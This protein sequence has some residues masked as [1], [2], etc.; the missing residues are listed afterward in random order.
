MWP[1]SYKEKISFYFR[2]H[3]DCLGLTPVF[4]NLYDATLPNFNLYQQTPNLCYAYN[5]QYWAYVLS[6]NTWMFETEKKEKNGLISILKLPSLHHL[7]I[8]D[9]LF[10]HNTCRLLKISCFRR[11]RAWAQVWLCLLQDTI[12]TS[13]F[14]NNFYC[15]CIHQIKLI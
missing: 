12:T 7:G 9:L 4:G 6:P 13:H 1:V 8:I 14:L 5:I 10:C 15:S 3:T 11:L 2:H